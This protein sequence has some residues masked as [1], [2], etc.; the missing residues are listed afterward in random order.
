MNYTEWSYLKC[1]DRVKNP[2]YGNGT[3]IS[4]VGVGYVVRFDSGKI[5]RIYNG[6]L[7]YVCS[8]GR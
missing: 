5:I 4:D 7:R 3:I 6:L 1:G 8:H 2:T